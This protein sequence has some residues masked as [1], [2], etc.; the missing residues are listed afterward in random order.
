MV[1]DHVQLRI[2]KFKKPQEDSVSLVLVLLVIIRILVNIYAL[3]TPDQISLVT[4][5]PLQL[6]S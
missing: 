6:F 3:S 1:S 2:L 4:G 5:V